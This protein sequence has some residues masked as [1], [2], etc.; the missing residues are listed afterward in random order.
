MNS[1]NSMPSNF[2]RNQ[3]LRSLYCS[4][5]GDHCCILRSQI[6]SLSCIFGPKSFPATPQN[7]PT[8]CFVTCS[9]LLLL[10]YTKIWMIRYFFFSIYV[11]FSCHL[12]ANSIN[13]TLNFRRILN[14]LKSTVL[15]G[16]NIEY[17]T[18]IFWLYKANIFNKF[19]LEYTFMGL[20]ER[21]QL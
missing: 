13:H 16:H 8:Q 3:I 19:K 9:I 5:S 2:P 17:F 20:K 18:I 6:S 15:N 1:I 11:I 7:F 21:A 10:Y 12:H 4:N 14:Q